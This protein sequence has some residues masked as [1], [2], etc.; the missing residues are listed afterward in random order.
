M[1]L[2]EAIYERKS[3]RAYKPDPVPKEVI[4]EILEAAT[5]APSS[6]NT[7]PWEIAVVGGEAMKKLA[8]ECFEEAKSGAKPRADMVLYAS[9]WPEA[10]VKRMRENGKRLFGLLGIP[11][12]D[13]EKRKEFQLS[14]FKFF[15]APQTIFISIDKALGVYSL[16]DCGCL[17]QNICL[18]AAA[19]GLGTCIIYSGVQ[20]PDIIR[21]Y[22]QIPEDKNIIIAITIGYID[23]N[24]T[25][26]KFRSNRDPLDNVV[27]WEGF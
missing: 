13:R 17:V 19:K 3:I 11:R 16:F 6:I 26:N 15:D 24:A 10:C 20:Y 4:A 14:M 8:E 2:K 25:V 5:R 1:E 12:E 9:S 7:Q 27:I 18:M 23:E 22:A 21:K